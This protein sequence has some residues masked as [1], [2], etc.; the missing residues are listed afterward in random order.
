[1]ENHERLVRIIEKL[2]TGEDPA[3][4]KAEAQDLLASLDAEELSGAEQALVEAGLAPEDMRHLCS[5][6]MEMC[7][8]EVEKMKESL[9]AGHVIH[10][11][12]CEHEMILGFLDDLEAVNRR[13]QAMDAYVPGAE[14]FHRLAHIA[15]HLVGAEPHHR[16]EEEVLFPEVERRGIFGPPQVMR[17]EHDDLRR[18]KHELVDLAEKA[19]T[20]DFAAFKRR[21]DPAAKFIVLT[22][23]DH[24]FK[25]NNI[26]YPAALAAIP[27]PEVWARMKQECDA[28]GYCCFTPEEDKAPAVQST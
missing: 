25:E 21:L 15:D 23:R 13:I 9:K 17:H 6:H 7:G 24:I 11:L 27:E 16:R 19:A 14:E 22:L 28:I 2:N 3:R 4:V 26:L 10:T 12:V 18:R 20:M 5:V 1:M 8:G